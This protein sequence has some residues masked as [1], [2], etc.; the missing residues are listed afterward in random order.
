[1]RESYS[2]IHA[3]SFWYL[4]IVA[5]TTTTTV[6]ALDI[7]IP[8]KD[9]F[10]MTLH[11][12]NIALIVSCLLSSGTTDAFSLSTT[13]ASSTTTT[14]TA[15][16]R[17]DLIV[18]SAKKCVNDHSKDVVQMTRI[19]INEF[20]LCTATAVIFAVAPVLPVSASSYSSN[21]DR[22]ECVILSRFKRGSFTFSSY[23]LHSL[24]DFI[25]K[26]GKPR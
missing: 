6:L 15:A 1:M 7:G 20:L 5:V 25:P 21:F 8:I 2:V 4:L 14:T 10:I 22:C 9:Y 17:K 13:F 11:I 24:I 16:T 3:R 26:N 18:R 23:Q 19:N 12:F